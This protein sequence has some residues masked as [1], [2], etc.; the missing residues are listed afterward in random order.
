LRA[1]RVRGCA[2]SLR[3]GVETEYKGD[4][5]IVTVADR[6]VEKLIARGCARRFPITAFTAR[7]ARGSGWKASSAGTW[8]RWMGRRTSLTGFRNFACRWDW[9]TGLP[10]LP[11]G[12]DGTLVAG[13]IYD[14]LRD[15]LFTAER[16]RARG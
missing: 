1:R 14:P 13:V 7:R 2:S 16:G 12:E 4:V 5:D 3:K 6:T 10:A 8:T 15:E 11:A 9:S